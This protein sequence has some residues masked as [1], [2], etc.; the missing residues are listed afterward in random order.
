MSTVVGVASS[1]INK[2][3]YNLCLDGPLDVGR[4][5]LSESTAASSVKKI[6]S[7]RVMVTRPPT[8]IRFAV[9]HGTSSRTHSGEARAK[10]RQ[11]TVILQHM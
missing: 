1:V 3:H 4:M 8:N 5:K 9:L 2:C 6:S 11:E 7:V 10:A